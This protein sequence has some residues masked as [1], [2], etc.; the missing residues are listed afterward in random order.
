[1]NT[2]KK[3]IEQQLDKLVRL[4]KHNIESSIEAYGIADH[5]NIINS[6]SNITFIIDGVEYTLR[7]VIRKYNTLFVSGSNN[8][9][10]KTFHID[11]LSERDIIRLGDFFSMLEN[12]K[13][14]KEIGE[15]TCSAWFDTDMKEQ[16]EYIFRT[17]MACCNLLGLDDD[18]F[19]I[20]E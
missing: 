6:T 17:A 8:G 15:K 12:L 19:P 5:L 4:A 2:S 16:E 10:R 7:S 9:F 14:I 1:M 3:Q 18:L 11:K 20:K 13:V